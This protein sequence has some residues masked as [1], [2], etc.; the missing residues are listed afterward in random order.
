[1]MSKIGARGSQSFLRWGTRTMIQLR[2]SLESCLFC[3][4]SLM[5]LEDSHL[6]SRANLDERTLS[7]CV[8]TTSSG[9]WPKS[10]GTN[11]PFLDEAM[12]LQSDGSLLANGKM[13]KAMCLRLAYGAVQDIRGHVDVDGILPLGH[14]SIRMMAADP[15][16]ASGQGSLLAEYGGNFR[17]D[18][19]R[20]RVESTDMT[21]EVRAQ[22]AMARIW[23]SV[24]RG[25]WVADVVDSD[26]LKIL[27]QA[28]LGLSQR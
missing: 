15:T 11:R 18:N 21:E 1:M 23:Q 14:C 22:R 17:A 5:A 4:L 19:G 25:R 28:S 9:A 3:K 27:G 7:V 2:E 8:T 12:K 13:S 20:L 26:L 24:A 16:V 10:S 6:L